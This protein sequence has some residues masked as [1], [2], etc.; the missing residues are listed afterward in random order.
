MEYWQLY[1]YFSIRLFGQYIGLHHLR[2]NGFQY[3]IDLERADKNA[4]VPFMIFLGFSLFVLMI[5]NI[6]WVMIFRSCW[7]FVWVSAMYIPITN[8][9]KKVHGD[10]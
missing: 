4:V 6:S 9:M 2:I 3:F 1:Q 10:D 7:M 5:M 8:L